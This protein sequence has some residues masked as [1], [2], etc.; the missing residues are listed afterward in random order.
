MLEHGDV[1]LHGRRLWHIGD[2]SDEIGAPLVPFGSTESTV[3]VGYAIAEDGVRASKLLAPR[4]CI[5]KRLGV[6]GLT[7]NGEDLQPILLTYS[8][9]N[10][11][12]LLVQCVFLEDLVLLSLGKCL[13]LHGTKVYHGF[14]APYQPAAAFNGFIHFNLHFLELGALVGP[15]G[16][17]ATFHRQDRLLRYSPPSKL[18]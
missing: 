4:H 13:V 3:V 1:M 16:L 12:F 6:D 15:V 17:V 14:I 5:C 18:F 11:N 8:D 9:H 7:V 10:I 2:V